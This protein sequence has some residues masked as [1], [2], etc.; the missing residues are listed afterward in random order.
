MLTTKQLEILA[1]LTGNDYIRIGIT[2]RRGSPYYYYRLASSGQ[3]VATSTVESLSNRF[4]LV[5]EEREL[6]QL[7]SCYVLSDT[8]RAAYQ[9]FCEAKTKTSQDRQHERRQ[10]QQQQELDALAQWNARQLQQEE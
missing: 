8:G 10:V 7:V 1:A 3:P 2:Q 6:P 9:K 4:Y 5:R